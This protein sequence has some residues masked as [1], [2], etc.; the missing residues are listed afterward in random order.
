LWPYNNNQLLPELRKSKSKNQTPL[1]VQIHRKLHSFLLA[2]NLHFR[3]QPYT[4]PN[5]EK[6][7]LFILS[8]LNR[9]AISWFEPGLMDPSNSVHWM[10]D[11]DAFVNELEVNFGPHDPIRDAEKKSYG[12]HHEGW[13]MHCQIQYR[14]LEISG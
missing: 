8:Y 2:C 14:V 10:W 11:F 1:M 12:T 7:I 6:K 3:D 4:F 13:I 9:S 5:D